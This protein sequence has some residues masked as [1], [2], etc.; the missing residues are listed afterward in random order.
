MLM[1]PAS[2]RGADLEPGRPPAEGPDP[3]VLL[4]AGG[5]PTQTTW[6]GSLVGT[7][8]ARG[9]ARAAW[10]ERCTGASP[11]AAPTARPTAKTQA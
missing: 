8:P 9:R 11:R 1:S 10:R 4:E 2:S 7:T 3:G 6:T 5:G